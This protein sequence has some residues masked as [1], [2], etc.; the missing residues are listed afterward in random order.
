MIAW[1]GSLGRQTIGSLETVRWHGLQF[2]V[3]PMCTSLEG[4]SVRRVLE[5]RWE[6][7]SECHTLAQGRNGVPTSL[8]RGFHG[9]RTRREAPEERWAS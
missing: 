4:R 5:E 6:R 1:A 3:V 2:L 8:V 9:A 7:E